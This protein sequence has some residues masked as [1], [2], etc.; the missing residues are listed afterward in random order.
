MHHFVCQFFFFR[1]DGSE[2][3]MK[4]DP[5]RSTK[6][7]ARNTCKPSSSTIHFNPPNT[8]T[9]DGANS[10]SS[11]F[12]PPDG[13]TISSTNADALSELSLVPASHTPNV[14]CRTRQKRTLFTIFRNYSEPTPMTPDPEA[15]EQ[16]QLKFLHRS[17]TSVYERLQKLFEQRPIWSKSALSVV[18]KYGNDNLKYLLPVVGYYFSTGPWR[19]LWVRFGYDPRQNPNS[20]IYQTFDYRH[21]QSGKSIVE[22]K[23]SYSTYMLPYK[24]GSTSK[25]KISVIQSDLL[26]NEKL[27]SMLEKE[28]D[29]SSVSQSND[30]SGKKIG[31]DQLLRAGTE[32]EIGGSGLAEE[33]DASNDQFKEEIYI[34]K[35]GYIPPYRQMFYQVLLE[36][37]C[38]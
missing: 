19:N 10:C 8:N 21:R 38:C 30:N 9:K 32:D 27:N 16:L 20:F 1:G 22:A 2:S 4:Q 15:L 5:K 37:A 36:N 14:I 6:V 12:V 11:D 7:H 28:G 35:E 26:G 17:M 23:R 33:E 13:T 29:D 18:L 3:F 34:F 25:K 31:Q 24:S